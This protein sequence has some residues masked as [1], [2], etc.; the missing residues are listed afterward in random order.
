MHCRWTRNLHNQSAPLSLLVTTFV[1]LAS[2]AP[3][4]CHDHGSHAILLWFHSP[5][6]GPVLCCDTVGR[7]GVPQ[8]FCLS[9]RPVGRACT[10]E[11]NPP[12]PLG[13]VGKKGSLEENPGNRLRPGAEK[14]IIGQPLPDSLKTAQARNSTKKNRKTLIVGGG[15][16]GAFQCSYKDFPQTHMVR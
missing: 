4:S 6:N 5:W 11:S 1:P 2:A 9:K 10:P 3:W 7:V 14:T 12:P 15:G 16:V 13:V 8:C